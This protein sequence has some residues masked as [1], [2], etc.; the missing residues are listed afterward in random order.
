MEFDEKVY[1]ACE[2]GDDFCAVIKEGT[3]RGFGAPCRGIKYRA[4]AWIQVLENLLRGEPIKVLLVFLI[5][6]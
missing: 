2:F 5:K 4:F 3:G 6:G 1:L